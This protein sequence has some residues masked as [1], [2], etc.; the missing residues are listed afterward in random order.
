M[1]TGPQFHS[2]LLAAR[3]KLAEGRED[4]SAQ[5]RKGSG[6]YQVSARLTS[7]VDAILIDLY[8]AV[9]DGMDAKVARKLREHLALVPHGGFGRRHLAPYSDVDLMVL[10]SGQ[11]ASEVEKFAKS[12]TA[13]VFD[14]GLEFGHS[15]RTVGQAVQLAKTDVT[16]W[17]SLVES[18]LL[19][20][21][22][23][24]LNEFR[25]R[26]ERQ[27]GRQF[28]RLYEMLREARRAERHDYGETA[29]LLEPNVKRSRGGLR[30][31]HLL[32]WMGFVRFGAA[33]FHELQRLGALSKED[34]RQ[35][36]NAAE[37]LMRLRNELHFHA[38]KRRDVL[39]RSEQLRI[40]KQ[41]DFPGTRGLLPVETFMSEYFQHTRQVNYIVS[42]F[43]ESIEPKPSVAQVFAP[44]FSH[45]IEGNYRVGRKEISATKRGID[46][47]HNDLDEVLRLADLA[48]LYD[49]RIADRTWAAV[50]RAAPKY[51]GDVSPQ[52]AQRFLSLLAQPPRLGDLLRRLHELRVL[53][54]IIPAFA[55]ARCLLQFNEYHKFTVDEH[56]IRAVEEATA[57]ADQPGPLGEAYHQIKQK[58]ILHLALLIHDLGKG[59]QEDHSEVGRRIADD[60]ARRLGLSPRDADVLRFLVHR[61]LLMPH[62][63]FRR[64]LSDQ[65]MIVRFAVEV[66]APDV[67]RMLYVLSC[68]DLA[69]VGPGV[70]NGWK[71]EVLTDLYSRAMSQLTGQPSAVSDEWLTR[72]RAAIAS[73]R[74]ESSRSP[75]WEEQIHSLPASVLVGMSPES[76]GAMLERMEPLAERQ[77]VAWARY[78]KPSHTVEFFIGLRCEVDQ[79]IFYKLAGVLSSRGLQILS[80]DIYQLAGDFM[81]DRFVVED[82]DYRG[83]P[84]A[85]RI[86][87]IN[88]A[89]V[90]SLDH[91]EAPRFRRVW[92]DEHAESSKALTPLPTQVR[93]DNSSSDEFTILDVFALDRIGLLYTI[94]R[95]LYEMGLSI[96]LAKISTHLDQ[97]VDVFYVTD[98]SG[99]KVIDEERLQAI[100]EELLSTIDPA[101]KP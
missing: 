86:G 33:D 17:T 48:N 69:A 27:S 100:R 84:P 92:G 77:A 29:Y 41:F 26:F 83:E 21:Q 42:R 6:G 75:W 60:T 64:D 73:Q 28:N 9:L 18:R 76:I 36:H 1:P 68:A 11:A 8:N 5:H 13:E 90:K 14:V 97:V 93:V 4:L 85:E 87:S 62:L 50:F 55:N 10:H 99:V 89:L 71:I 51:S 79:P 44:M 15:V 39:D 20:G 47:L 67:L 65:E 94:S 35:L 43:V 98:L 49:K 30:D 38:G 59:E 72:K 80:A 56:C 19:A 82:P 16:I 96:R 66:G 22:Q 95:K 88:N 40:A 24:V 91:N 25:T 58:H 12:L 74:G 53:E 81:L 2:R 37:F 61:H 63:A 54:K 23:S 46:K 7:L 32:R 45:Q 78:L 52:T 70:L 34:G 3:Q 57:L 31:L 101:A